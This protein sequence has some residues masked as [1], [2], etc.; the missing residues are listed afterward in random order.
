MSF[1]GITDNQYYFWLAFGGITDIH[2]YSDG[3]QHNQ[4]QLLIQEMSGTITNIH[5]SSDRCLAGFPAPISSIDSRSL[6]E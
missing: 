4:H 3:W 1:G 6:K 2:F 5:F